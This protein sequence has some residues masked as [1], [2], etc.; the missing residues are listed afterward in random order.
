[1]EILLEAL[2]PTG[3]R[4][5]VVINKRDLFGFVNSFFEVL[6]TQIKNVRFFEVFENLNWFTL[7]KGVRWRVKLMVVNCLT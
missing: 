7:K 4:Q 1:V 6:S 3:E 2:P 5:S